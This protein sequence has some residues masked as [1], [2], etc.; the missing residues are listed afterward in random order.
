MSVV[1]D[2]HI[3]IWWLTGDK[4][5]SQAERDGLDADNSEPAADALQLHTDGLNLDQTVKR[6]LEL[7]K[8]QVK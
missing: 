3:W 4:A 7:I 6:V 1:L 8:Q 5:L 2:T